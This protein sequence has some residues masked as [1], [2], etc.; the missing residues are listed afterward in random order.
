[1]TASEKEDQFRRLVVELRLMQGS[2]EILQQRL[3]L[4]RTA[5]T[6]LRVADSSLKALKDVEDGTPILVPM[7]GGAFVDAKLGDLS[8]VI[9]GIGAG[10][11]LEMDLEDALEDVSNRLSEVEKAA[12]SVQQQLEQIIGQMQI[13]Q[14][15][16]N[17]LSTELQGEA[18]GV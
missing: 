13:H 10:A 1:M 9:V 6:D 18:V 12:K 16:I 14:D 4:L 11:S 17:R 15:G 5:L 7:G 8:K 3:D 2:A